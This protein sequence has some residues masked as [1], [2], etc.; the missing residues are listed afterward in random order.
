M[1]IKT[2]KEYLGQDWIAV[3]NCI[4][5]ALKSDISLLNSTNG[6]ILS[7]SGKQLRPLLSLV[8][9]RAFKPGEPL[10]DA[11]IRYAAAPQRRQ[12]ARCR[13]RPIYRGAYTQPR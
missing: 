7:N 13:E 11:A 1:D 2:L 10:A 12:G 6:S 4:S 3:Q 9:A 8:L 5:S